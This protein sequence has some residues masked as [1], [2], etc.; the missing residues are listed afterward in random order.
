MPN[1]QFPPEQK[2]HI[3]L[4]TLKEEH[5]VSDIASEYGVHSSAIHRCKAELL[6]SADKVFATSRKAEQATEERKK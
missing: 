4:E 5:L 3:V 2:F 1:K 6:G